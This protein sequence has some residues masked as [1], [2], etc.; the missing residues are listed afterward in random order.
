MKL[1][2]NTQAKDFFFPGLE[3]I[4]IK[5]NVESSAKKITV[6]KIINRIKSYF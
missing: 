3:I 6:N 5:N 4:S 1:Y 2:L